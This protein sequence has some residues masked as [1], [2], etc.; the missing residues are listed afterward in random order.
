[1]TPLQGTGVA[2]VEAWRWFALFTGHAVHSPRLGV[3]HPQQDPTHWPGRPG[4]RAA[5]DPLWA[6]LLWGPS[7]SRASPGPGPPVLLWPHPSAYSVPRP[8]RV[9]GVTQ[10]P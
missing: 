1:M 10:P 4:F 2:T 8:R 9:Q 6:S 3:P 7:P 5:A